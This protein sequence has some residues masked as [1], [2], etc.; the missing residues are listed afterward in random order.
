ML[1]LTTELLERP[2]GELRLLAAKA[3]FER[4]SIDGAKTLAGLLNDPHLDV[5]VLARV[6]LQKLAEQPELRETILELALA[7]LQSPNWQGLEQ[8]SH[9][10]GDLDHKPA[11]PR[12]LE[13]IEHERPDVSIT[14]AWALSRLV[15]PETAPVMLKFAE[16]LT[17]HVPVEPENDTPRASLSAAQDVLLSHVFQMFGLLKYAEAEPLLLKFVP[18]R[19]DLGPR[20]RGAAV[21]ALG[22]VHA[23]DPN[24]DV[25]RALGQR[26]ADAADFP[27]LE[28]VEV[29]ANAAIGLGR[30]NVP[31]AVEVLRAF[32]KNGNPGDRIREACGWALEQITG[33]DLPDPATKRAVPA[34][35][36]LQPIAE[37]VSASP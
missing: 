37:P 1:P 18:R 5:R 27:R 35:P 2:D 34:T 16:R 4:P 28:P 20:S 26:V 32:Y 6:S 15:V 25:A 17:A 24:P 7:G 19:Y 22:Y 21:F 9:L 30:M 10:V 12:L 8:S 11:A 3:I 31:D 13:L 36:F 23:G 14:A 33:E 29:R